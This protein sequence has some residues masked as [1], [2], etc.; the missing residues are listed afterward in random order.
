METIN[1]FGQWYLFFLSYIW[2][3]IQYIFT[4]GILIGGAC[5][6]LI[7]IT[8]SE[9]WQVIGKFFS[10][11]IEHAIPALMGAA[12]AVVPI[13]LAITGK[14]FFSIH[15]NRVRSYILEAW[16]GNFEKICSI[17]VLGWRL[18]LLLLI[19]NI[20]MLIIAIPF[21]IV[22]GI[23][24]GLISGFLGGYEKKLFSYIGEVMEEYDGW[25]AGQLV[26][27]YEEHHFD[28]IKEGM[29][30]IDLRLGDFINGILSVAIYTVCLG[31]IG[32]VF[33]FLWMIPIMFRVLRFFVFECRNILL[34]GPGIAATGVI[35]IVII[36]LN[37]LVPIWGALIAVTVGL[38]VGYLR[39]LPK[40]MNLLCEGLGWYW[41]WL[42]WLS[43]SM[44]GN[45]L[46]FPESFKKFSLA[47]LLV[48][49]NPAI[50]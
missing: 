16:W 5:G 31:V 21:V 26:K 20:P 3:A 8:H 49:N 30:P 29:R 48:E 25:F 11:L 2:I 36:L 19:F 14:S 33:A 24:A 7:A 28:K 13:S 43:G 38:T 4:Y 15:K 37:L 27:I 46:R 1:L 45:C 35:W 39:W 40:S 6:L 44:E 18:K 34:L 12:I 10:G 22:G 17:Q 42:A 47:E 9:F 41:K 32:S 50:K 23:L